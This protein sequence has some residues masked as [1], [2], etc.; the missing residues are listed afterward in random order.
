MLGWLVCTE[1]MVP[2][3][4]TNKCDLLIAVGMRFDDRVT[5]N[6]NTYAKQAKIIHL[7]IDPAEIDKN[8]KCRCPVV[9]R[10]KINIA[11]IN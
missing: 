7:E 9:R 11:I 2:M 6:L 8:V 4:L 3:Y 10:C 5:G 1:I